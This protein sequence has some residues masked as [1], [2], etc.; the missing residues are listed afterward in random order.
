MPSSSHNPSEARS[1]L[2]SLRA[3]LPP[4]PLTLSEAFRLAELA[5]NVLLEH[6]GL[7]GAPIPSEVVSELPRLSVQ[8]LRGL[9]VSGSS[10]WDGA[11]WII[12]LKAEEPWYRQRFTLMHEF[13][14]ILWRDH[15]LR[16]YPAADAS[17]RTEQL[18]N[19]F[20]GCLLMPKRLLKR[21]WGEGVQAPSKVAHLFEVSEPA[22]RV[23]L[24]QLGLSEPTPR[25]WTASGPPRPP[26][27]DPY[28]RRSAGF[29]PGKTATSEAA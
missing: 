14:H 22:A 10:Y 1:V 19:Y 9:P 27:G 21:A 3:L 23:R 5:A 13:W 25:C 11:R 16:T 28:Y 17:Q 20:A 18:A 29:T 6:L 8:V 26:A 7:E 24:V 2:A 12:A 4:R 15:E